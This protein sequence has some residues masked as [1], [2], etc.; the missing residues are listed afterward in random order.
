MRI[1]AT[2]Q[3]A[4]AGSA[5]LGEI[6]VLGDHV[7]VRR[8]LGY[9]P[10]EFGLYPRASAE[11]MLDHFALLKGIADGR[12]R[13]ETV[14]ALL[15]QTNLYAARK[16]KLGGFSGGMR[17]RFGIAVAL[18]GSPRLIIVDEPTAGLDP[19]E[20]A[21][22]LNL[23]SELGENAVV[24]LSTHIV[25]DVSDLCTRM[26]IIEGGQILL[27]GEPARA[28]EAVRGRVW[29]RQVERAELPELERA[30]PVISTTLA[31]G[32]TVIHVHG[33][34]APDP[35]FEP[36]EP[37]LKD[38]YFTVIRGIRIVPPPDPP[39][40]DAPADASAPA[41]APSTPFVTRSMDDERAAMPD[42]AP[43][44]PFGSNPPGPSS[45]PSPAPTPPAPPPSGPGAAHI[46]VFRDVSPHAEVDDRRAGISRENRDAVEAPRPGEAPREDG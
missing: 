23:L 45:P 7:A 18:I 15:R 38:V 4:D 10:Q 32:R 25:E 46:P 39:P 21:R 42:D 27:E 28:V 30:L 33:D 43:P 36:V 9:L 13:R 8:T 3:E 11:A 19:A 40:P 2:L 41:S 26:A 31:G 6:D 1:L 35:S 22:F 17:Q 12:E 5:R 37:D 34:A 24:I 16:Q 29:R 44:P 14:A 20:R